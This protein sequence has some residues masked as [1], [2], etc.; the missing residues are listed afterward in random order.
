[1]KNIKEKTKLHEDS[2]T[3]KLSPDLERSMLKMFIKQIIKTYSVLSLNY[4]QRSLNITIERV[5]SVV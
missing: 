3:A 2:M 1:M 5:R 4:I